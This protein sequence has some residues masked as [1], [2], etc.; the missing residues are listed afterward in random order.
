ELVRAMIGT[1]AQD[2]AVAVAVG[3]TAQAADHDSHRTGSVVISAEPLN[4]RAADGTLAI[5]D[6]AF[7]IHAGEIAGLAAVEGAGHRELLRALA[8][9]LQPDSGL[10]RVPNSVGYVPEDRTREA[11]MGSFSLTENVALAGSGHAHGHAPWRSLER[12]TEELLA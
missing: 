10:L 3:A 11:L 7:A 1:S 9:R 2:E 5:R 12:R 6:A 4:L 8:G